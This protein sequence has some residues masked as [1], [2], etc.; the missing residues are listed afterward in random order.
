MQTRTVIKSILTLIICINT[1]GAAIVMAETEVVR[2]LKFV[3]SEPIKRE[4]PVYPRGEQ[5]LANSGMVELNF[6]VDS[7]GNIF[8]P[9]VERS[10]RVSFEAAA[11]KA[12]AKYKY[13]PATLD[14]KPIESAQ[15]IRILFQIQNDTDQVS[16]KFARNYKKFNKLFAQEPVDKKRLS[17]LIKNM[18]SAGYLTPYAYAYLNLSKYRYSTK[19][20]DKADQIEAIRR[21][22]LFEGKAG[23]KG[24]FLDED[25]RI[26]LRRNLVKL[27]IESQH[28]GGALNAFDRLLEIDSEA[29]TIF[30]NALD[31]IDEIYRSDKPVAVD[32][33]VPDR[34]Y[35][36]TYLFKKNFSIL[37]VV[38]QISGLKLRCRNKFAELEF[39]SDAEYQVPDSWGKCHV[40]ILGTPK[41]AAKLVQF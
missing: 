24:K 7:S 3:T 17:S 38:G 5:K 35:N 39:N 20:G 36:L 27:G 10:T 21:L 11:L 22:L 37:D 32:I 34:G 13:S 1:Y 23:E 15:T 33:E 40:Q 9:I 30:G 26:N 4:P 12:V 6:M 28:Y 14:G 8:E 2:A 41:T 25:M 19:F 29:E 18:E 31:Q 16:I